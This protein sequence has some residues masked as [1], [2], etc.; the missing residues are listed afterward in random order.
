MLL[1]KQGVKR[2]HYETGVGFEFAWDYKALGK[3]G[4]PHLKPA[5]ERC[6]ILVCQSLSIVKIAETRDRTGDL[7]IF[8][9]TLSQLSYRGAANRYVRS[10]R[11]CIGVVQRLRRASSVS[12]RNVVFVL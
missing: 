7:Q 4:K 12:S 6:C 11:S 5:P 3:A 10:D 1:R 2:S 8:S 9:L